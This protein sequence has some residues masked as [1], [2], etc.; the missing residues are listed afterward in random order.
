M[1][2]SRYYRE[3]RA[4]AA[5]DRRAET[6]VSA[7]GP[8]GVDQIPTAQQAPTAARAAQGTKGEGLRDAKP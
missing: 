1:F 6:E 4:A 8:S 5:Y 3:T 7:G 2:Y